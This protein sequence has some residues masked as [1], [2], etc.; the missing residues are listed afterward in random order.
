MI[1]ELALAAALA[2]AA[3]AVASVTEVVEG[4]YLRLESVA[5]WS[6]ASSMV[7]GDSVRWDVSVSADAPDPG[8]V[9][10]GVRAEGD[11]E[12]RVD[13][14]RCP[15]RW[16]TDGCPGGAAR[17]RSGWS[18]PRDGVEVPLLAVPATEVA[19]LRFA[20]SLAD[21]AAGGSTAVSIHATVAGETVVAGS[22]GRLAVTG[23]SS[24]PWVLAGGA[25]LLLSG[26]AFATVR[27]RR[28]REEG[29]AG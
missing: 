12:L 18:I 21:P 1:A 13:A 26:G 9:S 10:I 3:P 24:I 28:P 8:T 5:D 16:E 2:V 23:L 17:V 6:A 29:E 19:H 20:I 22:A 25:V 4:R 11:A 15:Q 27:R 14:A 7:A